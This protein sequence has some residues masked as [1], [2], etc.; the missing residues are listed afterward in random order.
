MEKRGARDMGLK[1]ENVKKFYTDKVAVEGITLE[2]N[3]PRC[4]WT[5]R[6][7]WSSGKPLQ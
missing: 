7:K 5:F 2:M 3:K 4:I 6:Y 1:L